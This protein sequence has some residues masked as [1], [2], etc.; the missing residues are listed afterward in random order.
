MK[1]D[2]LPPYMISRA[3]GGRWQSRKDADGSRG[4]GD[5]VNAMKALSMPMEDKYHDDLETIRSFLSDEQ[6]I[7]FSKAMAMKKVLHECAA[8]IRETGEIWP[9][10]TAGSAGGEGA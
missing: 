9:A 1:G 3:G 10:G 6:G 7:K 2:K 5:A 8:R 4:K